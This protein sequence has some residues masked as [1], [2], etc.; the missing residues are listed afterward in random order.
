M[1]PPAAIHLGKP[2]TAI[3]LFLL[4]A[5]ALLSAL[6]ARGQEQNAAGQLF[7]IR[8]KGLYGFIDRAGRIL[9]PPQFQQVQGFSDGLCAVMLNAKW[10]YLDA[11]GRI[12]VP[13]QFHNA[14][15]FH[16]GL[17]AVRRDGQWS[18]IDKSGRNIFSGD[19]EVPR[20]NAGFSQGL[21]AVELPRAV[22]AA[23][24]RAQVLLR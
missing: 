2:G 3:T 23:P 10:G 15:P 13:P 22:G 5:T 1:S 12:V 20:E 21:A 17:A 4:A 11:T 9:V 6:L 18:F 16:E 14:F 7:A 19:F 24:A 8:Q